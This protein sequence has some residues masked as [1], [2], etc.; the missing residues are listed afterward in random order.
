[1]KCEAPFG[2]TDGL[3]ASSLKALLQ[4]E[5]IK[6]KKEVTASIELFPSELE[7]VVDS[8]MT[9]FDDKHSDM[10]AAWVMHRNL[11]ETVE[12][13]L[14]KTHGPPAGGN[15]IASN[16]SDFMPWCSQR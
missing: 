9:A 16:S 8:C 3:K 10:K 2:K 5:G 13:R 7:K 6:I 12:Q 4:Q 11:M 1:M 14:L 15:R